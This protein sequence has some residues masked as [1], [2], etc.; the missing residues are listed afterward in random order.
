MSKLS[1]WDILGKYYGFPQCCI[2]SFNK[3][4]HVGKG[5]LKL[6]G[7]GY[8]P[9]NSCNQKSEEELLDYIANNRFALTSFP[10]AEYD[11]AIPFILDSNDFS[12]KEKYIMIDQFLWTLRVVKNNQFKDENIKKIFRQIN[13]ILISQ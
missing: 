4:L 12:I 8:I 10:D 11:E 1:S 3:K 9:C 2:D 5:M 7:T 13:K 6:C